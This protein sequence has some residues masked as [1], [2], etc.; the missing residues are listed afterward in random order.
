MKING[1]IE[2]NMVQ[3]KWNSDRSEWIALSEFCVSIGR[4]KSVFQRSGRTLTLLSLLPGAVLLSPLVWA[5]GQG[6]ATSSYYGGM[7]EQGGAG[8]G[9]GTGG[10]AGAGSGA[11]SGSKGNGGRGADGRF[12]TGGA[13]GAGG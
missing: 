4:P 3:V 8:G 11:Q 9:G 5:D 1:E 13:G 2:P 12:S 10:L 6:G 7:G